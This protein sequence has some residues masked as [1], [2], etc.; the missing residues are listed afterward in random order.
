MSFDKESKTVPFAEKKL[1]QSS[2][3]DDAVLNNLSSLISSLNEEADSK[4]FQ[5]LI[6]FFQKG[7]VSQVIQL[8][9][10]YAQV[11]NHPKFSKSTTLLVKTLRLLDSDNNMH[12]YG[13]ILINLILTGH[14]R[15]LYRG[16]NNIRASLTNPILRLMK[17]IEIGR[18]HV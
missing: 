2:N 8:W 10:Y 5:S 14:V 6:Q 15:V 18:A 3:V 7:Y 4:N 17:E 1:T 11:N 13:S 16:L 12:E 9:S